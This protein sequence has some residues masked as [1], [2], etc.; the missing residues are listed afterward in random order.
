MLDAAAE[1]EEVA[2]FRVEAAFEEIA[3]VVVPLSL[4]F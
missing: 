2:V 3:P 4:L 1:M